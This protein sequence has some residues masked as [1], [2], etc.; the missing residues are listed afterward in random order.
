[1]T[2]TGLAITRVKRRQGS[3]VKGPMA[4]GHHP[5]GRGFPRQR[6]SMVEPK[7]LIVRKD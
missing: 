3:G 7:G 6:N 5:E 4:S 2:V 1:M